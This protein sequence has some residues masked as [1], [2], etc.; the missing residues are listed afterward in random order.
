MISCKTKSFFLVLQF[1]ILKFVD[2]V[3]NKKI[4]KEC[5]RMKKIVKKYIAFVS[6]ASRTVNLKILETWLNAQRK[7]GKAFR[8]SRFGEFMYR[9]GTRGTRMFDGLL[10]SLDKLDEN[11][12]QPQKLKTRELQKALR[13]GKEIK[14]SS[15]F[16]KNKNKSQQPQSKQL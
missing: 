6:V 1:F 8:T 2:I 5:L 14:L 10:S 7:I 4:K 11:F 3:F 12:V 13:D 16:S 15:P 9:P